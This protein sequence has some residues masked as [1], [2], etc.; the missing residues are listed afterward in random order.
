MARAVDPE[1]RNAG[2][3]RLLA[4]AVLV[5]IVLHA[6]LI[7]AL[8]VLREAKKMLVTAPPLNARLA[9]PSAPAALPGRDEPL[10]A[11]KPVPRQAPVAKAAP[12]PSVPVPRIEPM[13]PLAEAAPAV[14]A[15]AAAPAVP[16]APAKVEPSPAAPAASAP[17]AGTLAQYR[18]EIIDLA[19]RYKKYP[20]LAI[21]NGW[22][23]RVEVRMVI[24]ANGA[25]ALLGVKSSA[26]YPP[27]DQEALAMI[28][29]AQSAAI[30]PPALLGREFSL[31]VP[32]IFSLKEAGS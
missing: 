30:I 16:S 9:K 26:G 4:V 32:V 1:L 24:G 14:P 29:K 7:V 12:V 17:D 10:P 31:E 5:S 11:A 19:K 15:A 20:R 2:E 18:L 27:L 8:P 21:D 25:V 22:E 6:A 13:K 3:Y 23:G 28:R